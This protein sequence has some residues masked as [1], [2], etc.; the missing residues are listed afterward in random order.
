VFLVCLALLPA[1][2]PAD[3]IPPL[4]KINPGDFEPAMQA[5]VEEA[6]K[7]ARE[8]PDNAELNGQLGMLMQS[9]QQLEFAEACYRRALYTAPSE[10]RWGYYLGV[11]LVLSGKQAEAVTILKSALSREP[12]YIPARLRLAEALIATGDLGGSEEIYRRILEKEPGVAE[13]YYGMGRIAFAR[14]KTDSA[15]EYYRKACE[16]FPNYGAAHYALAIAY[17]D[18]GDKEKA[19]EHFALNKKFQ[20]TMPP[21]RDPLLDA[22]NELNDGAVYHLKKGVGLGA[23]GRTDEAIAEH[24]R[25][26]ELDPNMVQ[27]H[28]NLI[29]YYGRIGRLDRAGEHYKAALALSPNLAELHYDYAVLNT[30]KGDLPQAAASF[31]RALEINPSYPEAHSKYGYVLMVQGKLS[32]AEREFRL[33]LDNDP[34]LRAAHFNLARILI[35]QNKTDEAI[36]HLH[37]TL[38]PEDENTP[39]YMYALG[40]AYYRAGNYQEALRYMREARTRAASMGLKDLLTAIE[41][42]LSVVERQ[43]TPP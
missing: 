30:L 18:L 20:T 2:F 35:Q 31:Q 28:L 5:Q 42:D 41:K 22:I 3:E 25:A 26:L 43:S 8:N 37:K 9:Y 4:P 34:N 33:A 12:D 39:R 32:E 6:Y 23:A 15:A 7:A 40:A 29:N 38:A 11:V 17:R 27:A 24:E 19:K 14:K 16:L 10:F 1:A 21:L 13:A 36:E